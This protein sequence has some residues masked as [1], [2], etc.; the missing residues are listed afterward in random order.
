MPSSKIAK[1]APVIKATSAAPNG[2][3]CATRGQKALTFLDPRCYLVCGS[4]NGLCSQY[5]KPCT[6]S[7][8]YLIVMG[9]FAPVICIGLRL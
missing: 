3:G 7:V 4:G 9:Y 6:H 5:R 2:L 1:M 8:G